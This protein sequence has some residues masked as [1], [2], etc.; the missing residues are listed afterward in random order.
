MDLFL[1][2]KV[3]ICSGKNGQFTDFIMWFH[4]KNIASYS[5]SGATVYMLCRNKERGE[6]A[7]DKIRSKTGNE[8][9]HLEVWC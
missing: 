1:V 9:V 5:S 8:N 6:V 7:L 4:I 3:M 2:L